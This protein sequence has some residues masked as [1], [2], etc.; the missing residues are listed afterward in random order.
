VYE[1]NDL[2]AAT[3]RAESVGFETTLVM[4]R[5]LGKGE[6]IGMHHYSPIGGWR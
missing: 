4:R 6:E 5:N 1:T 2:A 3:A